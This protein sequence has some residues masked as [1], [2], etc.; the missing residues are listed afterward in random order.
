[1]R[2]TQVAIESMAYVLPEAIWTSLD[3]EIRLAALYERLGLPK[4]RLE[5]MTG[6]RERRFW[7]IDF[8]ASEASA[9]AGEAVLK[10][11][12]FKRGEMNLLVHAAVCRD[13]LEPATAS[14]VHHSLGLDGNT[15][16]FDLSNAC[17]GFLNAMVIAAGMIESGQIERA[18]ICSGE[19][20]R[21]LMEHTLS[22]LLKPEQTRKSIKPYF[23][24]L[25]IG[26]GAVGAVLCRSDLA[27]DRPRL[28]AAA[29]ATDTSHSGLCE[30]DSSGDG[31]A[32]LTDSEEL[33]IAGIKV[34]KS[35]WARF[36]KVSGWSASTPD[37]VITH[38]VGSAHTRALFEA[39]GLEI[40]K[41]FST[42]E[43]LGNIGSVSCPLTLASAI[44]A[45]AY[46][47]GQKA[48][49]LGIGS[50]LSSLMLALEWPE[51]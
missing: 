31:L 43:N 38:Q 48:A 7:P 22:E 42:F 18:L 1:M 25:T 51:L 37:S 4:G 40:E 45:A 5:L 12:R 44:E 24:N 34:A 23:A 26:A 16:I 46:A 28:S 8:R 6:I 19:N 20:G 9:L 14:Y 15:Q 30:G 17:L 29:V 35:A 33:L 47:P 36:C 10:Q 39:L 21:P 2:F 32:M 49:L 50:G 11:T 3:I 27:P 13:R 41:D